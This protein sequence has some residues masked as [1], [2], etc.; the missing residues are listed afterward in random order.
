MTPQALAK[1]TK[2][3]IEIHL[4]KPQ[5]S[6]YFQDI[7]CSSHRDGRCFNRVSCKV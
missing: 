1:V 6:A 5:R 4:M 2:T 3:L 7:F